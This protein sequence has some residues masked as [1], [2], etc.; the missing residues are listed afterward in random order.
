MVDS[1]V[2]SEVDSVTSEVINRLKSRYLDE[3][4]IRHGYRIVKIEPKFEELFH[5]M[6][7][8]LQSVVIRLI[9]TPT[10]PSRLQT[11]IP[12][13]RFM[14]RNGYD[15]GILSKWVYTDQNHN[16]VLYDGPGGQPSAALVLKIQEFITAL[17]KRDY[18][19]DRRQDNYDLVLVFFFLMRTV[20][21]EEQIMEMLD[22]WMENIRYFWYASF[23]KMA[24]SWDSL[25]HY[26]FAWSIRLL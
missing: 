6:S 19:V 22:Y 23:E 21:G 15:S 7:I 11:I 16:P 18:R 2:D 3:R 12:V 9:S 25:K 8:D 17:R 10:P 4:D 5:E 20:Y 13:I 14:H 26:P 24:D 1:L